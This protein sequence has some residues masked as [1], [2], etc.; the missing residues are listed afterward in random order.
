M[1]KA[2]IITKEYAELLGMAV[3][4]NIKGSSV[5]VNHK[6]LSAKGKIGSNIADEVYEHKFDKKTKKFYKE[7]IK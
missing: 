4:G 6:I 3:R 7:R 5:K 1:I 2:K